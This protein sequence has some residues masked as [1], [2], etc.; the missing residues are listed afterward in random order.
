LNCMKIRT[1]SYQKVF[2][3]AAYVNEKIGVEM[4][5]ADTDD[6]NVVFKTCKDLVN[7][8]GTKLEYE[9]DPE[10][11][12]PPQKITPFPTAHHF[13]NFT[14]PLQ[15]IDPKKEDTLE[16]INDA[17]SQHELDLLMGD[18]AKYGLARELNDK[19]R[20]LQSNE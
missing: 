4:E 18:A 8:W 7:S 16:K 12:A 2:P 20:K 1:I 10:L 9:F 15:S 3:L 6:E 11:H 19:K 14:Q 13:Q 17:T 5:L